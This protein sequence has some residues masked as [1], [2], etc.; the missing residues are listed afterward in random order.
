VAALDTVPGDTGWRASKVETTFGVTV[1][2]HGGVLLSGK[3][4]T[5]ALEVQVTFD[6]SGAQ[7]PDA[8]ATVG[9]PGGGSSS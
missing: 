3:G 2:D 4:D 5:A 9:D 6:R 1:L 7:P 8:P